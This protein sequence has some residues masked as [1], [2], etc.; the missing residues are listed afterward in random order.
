MVRLLKHWLGVAKLFLPVLDSLT[1]VKPCTP[2][3]RGVKNYW[4]TETET[5]KLRNRKIGNREIRDPISVLV[6][7][8]QKLGIPVPIPDFYWEPVKLYILFYFVR[9]N[10]GNCYLCSNV[11]S[12]EH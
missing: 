3:A 8:N 11:L 6:L 10:H 12:V 7:K 5:G 2:K 9:H 4:K 1:M